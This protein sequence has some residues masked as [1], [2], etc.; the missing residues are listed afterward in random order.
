LP[1]F[2]V[3]LDTSSA[4]RVEPPGSAFAIDR[5][6]TRLGEVRVR[7]YTFYG[8]EGFDELVPRELWVEVTGEAPSI[9]EATSEFTE[10]GRVLTP[11][12]A[13][14]GNAAIDDAAFLLAYETT[15][16]AER[17]PFI[18]ALRASSTGAFHPS[19]PLDVETAGRTIQ[20]LL[21]H[22]EHGR[23]HRAVVNYNEALK[24]WAPG[25]ELRA[26]MHLW[27]A[28]EALTK[29]ALRNELR[30]LACSEADL[31]TS[32]QIELKQLDAEVRRRL[33]FHGDS[34]VYKEAKTVSEGTEHAFENFAA[35]HP[36][37]GSVR[38]PFADHVRRSIV[39]VA[40]CPPD[41]STGLLTGRAAVPLESY[42]ITRTFRGALLAPSSDVLAAAGSPHPWLDWKSGL[43]AVAKNADGTFQV[44]FDEHVTARFGT[45]VTLEPGGKVEMWGPP[46]DPTMSAVVGPPAATAEAESE[47]EP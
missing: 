37:A 14:A 10:A 9:E 2:F 45:R 16:S 39:E 6:P 44:T 19:R 8:D 12:L 40:E 17:R 28:I 3:A 11:Y 4:L 31:V 33:L 42:P 41:L 46:K 20:R 32:W 34:E 5:L 21:A 15:P 23:L 27:F 36:R 35:L 29:A 18:Q 30:R 25:S 38:A 1:E 22:R 47:P 24:A 13:F 26:V 43:R 7:W